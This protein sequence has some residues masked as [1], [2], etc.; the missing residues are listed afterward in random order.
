MKKLLILLLSFLCTACASRGLNEVKALCAKDGGITFY[1]TI[2]AEGYYDETTI[3]HFCWGP[4]IGGPMRFIEYCDFETFRPSSSYKL[5]KHGCFRLSKV[6]RKSGLCHP[7]IDEHMAKKVRG[8]TVSFRK[9]QCIHVEEIEKPQARYRYL[10]KRNKRWIDKEEGIVIHRSALRV[11]E[12]KTDKL[13]AELISY[14]LRKVIPEKPPIPIRSVHCK[15]KQVT[16]VK[17][18]FNPEGSAEVIFRNTV[19][20][21]SRRNTGHDQD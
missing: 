8:A 5:D 16:G 1:E 10:R 2:K 13:I 9:D 4:L 11:E 17:P 14:S 12:I 15:S 3:C 6:P 19:F 20:T 21:N 7:G 18:V